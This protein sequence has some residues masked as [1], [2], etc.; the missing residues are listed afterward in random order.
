MRAAACLS[1]LAALAATASRADGAAEHIEL[2]LTGGAGGA[3]GDSS[4]VAPVASARIGYDLGGFT[5]GVRLTGVLG[6]PGLHYFTRETPGASGNQAWSLLAEAAI[7]SPGRLQMQVALGAGIGRLVRAQQS[8]PDTFA[9]EGRTGPAFQGAIGVRYFAVPQQ[10]AVGVQL[11]GGL[12]S[13]VSQEAAS[14]GW[15]RSGMTVTGL[16]LSVSLALLPGAL[17]ATAGAP[18]PQASDPGPQDSF[19]S[20][21]GAIASSSARSP[22]SATRCE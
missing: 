14:P 15:A 10:L 13:N 2:E 4:V 8:V 21:R 5:P 9:L 1:F 19:F 3:V 22:C 16:S 6:P 12:W 7:H 17:A 18:R 11:S 20:S